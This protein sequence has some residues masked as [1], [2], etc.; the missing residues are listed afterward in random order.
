MIE[1]IEHSLEDN[2]PVIEDLRKLE[3]EWHSMGLAKLSKMIGLVARQLE[4]T[5]QVATG[6]GVTRQ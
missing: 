6:K 1:I 5:H 3:A 2:P 4:F